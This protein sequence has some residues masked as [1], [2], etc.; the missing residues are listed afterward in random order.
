MH[1]WKDCQR[2]LPLIQGRLRIFASEERFRTKGWWPHGHGHQGQGQ[3]IGW[4]FFN[5]QLLQKSIVQH[6]ESW[7][8]TLTLILQ[9]C[10]MSVHNKQVF[11]MALVSGSFEWS[12]WLFASGGLWIRQAPWLPSVGVLMFTGCSSYWKMVILCV[13]DYGIDVHIYI[14]CVYAYIYICVYA[15][16]FAPWATRSCNAWNL[17]FVYFHVCFVHYVPCTS[18][19][20]YNRRMHKVFFFNSCC[21]AS[22]RLRTVSHDFMA[23]WIRAL[24]ILCNHGLKM[25]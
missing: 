10:W 6:Q 11:N 9:I 2:C 12:F 25:L 19:T 18:P 23:Q 1:K 24:L 17:Q 5:I 8:W 22:S 20:V 15:S 4:T 3:L 16:T 21:G 13:Y 14:Y 7:K